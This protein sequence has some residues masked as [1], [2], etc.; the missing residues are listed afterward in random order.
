MLDTV[1]G[2]FVCNSMEHA[3]AVLR[4]LVARFDHGSGSDKGRARLERSKDSFA[5]PSGGGWMDCL[6]NIGVHLGSNVWLV[7]E[8]QIVHRQ[9]LVVRAEL[10]AHHGYGIYRAALGMLEATG[11]L[12]LATGDERALREWVLRTMLATYRDA[13]GQSLE[14][15]MDALVDGQVWA[16]SRAQGARPYPRLLWSSIWVATRLRASSA[17]R[18]RTPRRSGAACRPCTAPSTRGGRRRC[19][20]PRSSP[21]ASQA[22]SPATRSQGTRVACTRR[23]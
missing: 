21:P 13:E 22:A 11:N 15:H 5:Q 2:M 3:L 14:R 17:Q 10:G 1:R 8:V 6:I 12:A 23:R 4:L 9:L 16:L 20:R 7:G 19:C 18:G